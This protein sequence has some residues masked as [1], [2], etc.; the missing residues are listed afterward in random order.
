MK[1]LNLPRFK[2][3]QFQTTYCNT[4]TNTGQS[5]GQVRS[6]HNNP[7]LSP[8]EYSCLKIVLVFKR[9][10]SYYLLTIYV[11]SCML[12]IVSW[13]SFWLDNRSVPARVALGVTTLLTMSTQIAGVNRSLPPVAYTKAIDVW[14]GACVLFVFS[15]LLEFA[16]VNYASRSD[17]RKGKMKRLNPLAQMMEEEIE[18]S[19]SEDEKERQRER[20]RERRGETQLNLHCHHSPTVWKDSSGSLSL[21]YPSPG[22][23]CARPLHPQVSRLASTDHLLLSSP[24]AQY[25]G[26]G[27]AGGGSNHGCLECQSINNQRGQ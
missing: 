25:R 23:H 10:F 21:S 18:E 16:F 20:Q 22:P 4:I 11:P 14:S 6:G 7:S 1:D 9:E 19:D 26:G 12:V 15:A 13:V 2:L 3:E 24:T 17:Q 5:A 8:G 27:G